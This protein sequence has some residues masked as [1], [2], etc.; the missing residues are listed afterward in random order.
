MDQEQSV[1]D[2]KCVA[3]IGRAG[4]GKSTVGK[5]LEILLG[6]TYLSTGD[7][8]RSMKDE[9]LS[10]GGLANESVM[11]D[12]FKSIILYHIANG[13][14]NF[15]IDG[16]PRTED[17]I[18]F[19]LQVFDDVRVVE[20]DTNRELAIKRLINRRRDD[21]DIYIINNRQNIY[22]HEI[23]KIKNK[24][25]QYSINHRISYGVYDNNG[26]KD[27]LELVREIIREDNT[28]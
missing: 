19:L 23:T 27:I 13:H 22:D 8:A 4:S 1:P 15:I 11:R 14:T 21:D 10:W 18:D 20:L 24:L 7:I 17:Q 3:L 25:I 6:Y 16:M 5:I 12:T 28:L 9:R 26:D 2:I